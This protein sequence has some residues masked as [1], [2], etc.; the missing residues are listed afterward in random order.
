M[1]RCRSSTHYIK[2]GEVRN[3]PRLH[4]SENKKV[5]TR[6]D[7][8]S[9]LLSCDVY[10]I[11][12]ITLTSRAIFLHLESFV[13]YSVMNKNVYQHVHETSTLRINNNARFSKYHLKIWRSIRF[14]ENFI[15]IYVFF[16]LFP[17][18]WKWEGCFISLI[19][20]RGTSKWKM[21]V[22]N[23]GYRAGKVSPL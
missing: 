22:Q 7:F 3:A 5:F 9:T 16:A 13:W 12:K 21:Y 19:Y 15:Y 4:H 11:S 23:Y 6:T 17:P 1:L 18:L 20:F 10:N 14:G 2:W 8:Q